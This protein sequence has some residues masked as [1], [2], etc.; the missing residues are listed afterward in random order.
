MGNPWKTLT[1][2]VTL[3][4]LV[5]PGCTARSSIVLLPVRSRADSVREARAPLIS[6]GIN[7][8]SNARHRCVD[9]QSR[10][11]SKTRAPLLFPLRPWKTSVTRS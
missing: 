10:L 9:S 2:K 11:D 8:G 3:V 5:Q 7:A 1:A 4:A 6:T